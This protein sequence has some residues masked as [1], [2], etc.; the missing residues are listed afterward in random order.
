MAVKSSSEPLMTLKVRN[1]CVAFAVSLN[2]HIINAQMAGSQ[3][4]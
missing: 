4:I 3:D 1:K 2:Y